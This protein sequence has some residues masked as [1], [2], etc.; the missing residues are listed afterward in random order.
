[1]TMPHE[2]TRS[3]R[4]GHELLNLVAEDAALD[5]AVREQARRLLSTYPPPSE[6]ARWLAEDLPSLPAS[7]AVALGAAA[8]HFSKADLANSASAE[9][10]SV[11]LYTRRHYPL[12]GD[13]QVWA[14]GNGR[15]SPREW[16]LPEDWYDSRLSAPSAQ[17]TIAV[18]SD[19]R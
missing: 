9:T 2:R 15:R 1:M 19:S 18:P 16:L 13:F 5:A 7:A 6:I 17:V 11:L 12:S 14:N 8:D 4:W 3:L 10:A